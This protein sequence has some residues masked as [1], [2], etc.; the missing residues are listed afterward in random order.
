MMYVMIDYQFLFDDFYWTL[1][2]K[3]RYR[4]LISNGML[5]SFCSK[6]VQNR[7]FISL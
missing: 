6:Y 1:K 4:W 3:L 5:S 2:S 7:Y